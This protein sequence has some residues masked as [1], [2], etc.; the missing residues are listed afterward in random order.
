LIKCFGG[1]WFAE[2]G[3]EPQ[4]IRYSWASWSKKSAL[5]RM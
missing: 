2:I 3:F 5:N 1:D 4:W